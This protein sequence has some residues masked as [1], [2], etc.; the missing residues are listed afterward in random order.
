MSMLTS[1]APSIMIRVKQYDQSISVESTLS[2][3]MS[4]VNKHDFRQRCHPQR[5]RWEGPWSIQ[6]SPQVGIRGAQVRAYDDR[7]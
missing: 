4:F 7:A 1:D 2:A 6:I 3:S 5:V